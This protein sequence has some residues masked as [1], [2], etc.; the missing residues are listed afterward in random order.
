MSDLHTAIARFVQIANEDSVAADAVRKSAMD[1]GEPRPQTT[2]ENIAAGVMSNNGQNWAATPAGQQRWREAWMEQCKEGAT[3][4]VLGRKGNA[5]TKY[6]NQRFGYYAGAPAVEKSGSQNFGALLQTMWAQY[7]SQDPWV[8]QAI[9]ALYV[10][11]VLAL[12]NISPMPFGLGKVILLAPIALGAMLL[13]L[14]AIAYLA[15]LIVC[16]AKLSSSLK[17]NPGAFF[18][19]EGKTAFAF[20]ICGPIGGAVG[21][22]FWLIANAVSHA[23]GHEGEKI[24]PAIAMGTILGLVPAF[25]GA[26]I[27]LLEPAKQWIKP[28][29]CNAG[30][31]SDAG[32]AATTEAS[33]AAG[34]PAATAQSEAAGIAPTTIAGE[35]S[36]V[37]PSVPPPWNLG[38][39][40]GD[41]FG[42]KIFE[43]TLQCDL[44]ALDVLSEVSKLITQLQSVEGWK[45]NPQ[46][47]TEENESVI[48]FNA[49]GIYTRDNK[50]YVAEQA[51]EL[52]MIQ[53]VSPE[54]WEGVG[55]VHLQCSTEAPD[56]G[57][58]V[59]V[60]FRFGEASQPMWSTRQSEGL[61]A[62]TIRE[63]TDLLTDGFRQPIEWK[64]ILGDWMTYQLLSTPNGPLELQRARG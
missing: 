4:Y 44:S 56:D 57:D 33:K 18:R 15:G 23:A 48:S 20:L 43:T 24:A 6:L 31:K 51:G 40:F 58:L 36:V 3:A 55:Q 45:V 49:V 37:V 50:A 63:M 1:A 5:Y 17:K 12:L 16:L 7:R 64:F 28:I 29:K 8:Q 60:R 30:P 53:A 2:M 10:I 32:A 27:V 21:Y 47:K 42:P 41:R 22:V 61:I 14:V 59:T 13:S 11:W 62:L 34:T 26:S 38:G 35:S 46:I 25:I 52:V 39:L 54:R 19:K 9:A